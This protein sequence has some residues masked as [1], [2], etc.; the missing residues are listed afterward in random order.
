MRALILFILVLV[1]LVYILLGGAIFHFL[2]TEAE[3]EIQR[4]VTADLNRF[5]GKCLLRAFFTF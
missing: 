1:L 4:S 5:V 2:E 3:S